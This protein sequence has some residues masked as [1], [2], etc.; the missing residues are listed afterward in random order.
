MSTISTEKELLNAIAT[1]EEKHHHDWGLLK[2]EFTNTIESIL[3]INILKYGLKN[4]DLL[5]TIK[6]KLISGGLGLLAGYI[7]KKVIFSE[8]FPF[9]KIL[10]TLV[11]TEVALEVSQETE[12]ASDMLDKLQGL[13]HRLISKKS[14]LSEE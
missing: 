8:S 3:P 10:E 14:K 5:S 12:F 1:L 6:G 2:L 9:K 7:S 11:Q 13:I 4:V